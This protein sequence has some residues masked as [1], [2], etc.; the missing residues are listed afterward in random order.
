MESILL[1]IIVVLLTLLAISVSSGI[2]FTNALRYSQGER[3]ALHQK[4]YEMQQ[5]RIDELET[6]RNERKWL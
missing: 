2:N 1:G 6:E 3:I 4:V 5:E